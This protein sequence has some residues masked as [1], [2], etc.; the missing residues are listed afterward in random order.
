MFILP[1][2]NDSTLEERKAVTGN[3]LAPRVDKASKSVGSRLEH[4]CKEMGSLTHIF[5]H[6]KWTLYVHH[7]VVKVGAKE[8]DPPFTKGV[9]GGERMWLDERQINDRNMWIGMRRCWDL[10]QRMESD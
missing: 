10:V 5:S 9:T 1:S 7:I 4:D 8:S 2:S 6:L 3:L